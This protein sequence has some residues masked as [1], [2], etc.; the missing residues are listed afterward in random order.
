MTA[1][2][3]LELSGL[4]AEAAGRRAE[5]LRGVDIEVRRREI[6]GLVGETGAGKSMTAR[7]LLG[8]VP[9]GIRTTVETYRFDG[10][11]VTKEGRLAA[12][13][14]R[15]IGF[16]PQNPRASLNPVFTVADQLADA[17]RRLRGLR[18]QE[19][20]SEALRLLRQV[21]IPDPE[22]R[23]GAYPHELSG[24]MCQRV[25]IAIA[26]AG[27]P[28]LIIADEPTTGLDVTIQAEILALLRQLIEE[29]NAGGVLITHDIGVVAELCDS[30]AV[31]Y[32]GRVVDS[33]PTA[34]VVDKP[35]HPYAALLLRIAIDLDAGR[36][37]TVI[38]G[39]VPAPGET[40][41]GCVFAAR[42]PRATEKCFSVEPPLV[43]S[44][45]QTAFCHHPLGAGQS[46]ADA[47]SE[48]R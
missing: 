45:A 2:P 18:G 46:A 17:V 25:C 41:S 48:V 4:R 21:Q 39:T 44:G 5:I 7:A 10:L 6:L 12:L 9:S 29:E 30:V 13:L 22:R 34:D 1:T 32:A 16:V 31:M 23:M 15:S 3:I 28:Q 26:L 35:L 11:D 37:P 40:T 36:D 14:G 38:A 27:R 24:G 43:R 42:C 8:L 20:S 47:L 19:A 33:G